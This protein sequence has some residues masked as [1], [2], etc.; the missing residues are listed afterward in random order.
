LRETA[1]FGGATMFEFLRFFDPQQIRQ[2]FEAWLAALSD[3]KQ[4]LR[5]AFEPTTDQFV[6]GFEFYLKVIV[7]SLAV[8]ALVALFSTRDPIGVKFKMLASGLLGIIF[9]F[10]VAAAVHVPFWLLGGKASFLGTCMAYIYAAS[11]L[12]PL[13]AVSQWILVAGMPARLR[14][15]AL[16][17]ATATAAAQL[18]GQDEE[19]DKFT[20]Y[21]GSLLGLVLL[22]WL[23]VMTFRS[24]SFVHDLGGWSLAFAILLSWIVSIPLGLLNQRMASHIYEEPS[25]A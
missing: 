14:R 21:F 25:P 24:M 4:F 7:V 6:A 22:V 10:V 12:A 8:Y 18:A 20:F 17:P 5:P 15:Y 19:T 3:P 23:I 16:N 9:F 13:M 11:P 2:D 1:F